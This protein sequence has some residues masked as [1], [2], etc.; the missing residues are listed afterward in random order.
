LTV[1][2]VIQKS[3]NIGAAKIANKLGPA[4]LDKYLREF[5]FGSKSGI[6][7]AGESSGLLRNLAKAHSIIDRVTVAF[8]QG[9]SVTPL[10]LTMAL[11]AMGNGGVLME[12]HIVKEIVDPQ[13]NKVQDFPP[14]PVRRVMSERAAQQ[15]LAIME[16]VTQQGGT[17][18]EAAVPG[19][20]VAGKTG[21]AQ[22][23]VGRAYSHSKFSALFIGMVPA[24]KPVLAISII[25]DE[26]KG[27]IFGGVVA[28]PIFREIAAQSLRILGYYPKPE[29]DKNTPV[30]VKGGAPAKGGKTPK[31]APAQMPA[32]APLPTLAQLLPV[33]LKETKEP[34]K[35]MPDLK[36]CTIREVLD[37]LNQTGLKCR[38]EGSGLAVTQD[39]SPGT[40]LTPGATCSVRFQSNS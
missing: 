18:K 5:G 21:T 38:L 39:P 1:Q 25:I 7:L 32:V 12:P 13:G 24:D 34:A 40:A 2:Q 6:T 17:A 35:V 26:P 37:L 19:F 10:Q 27:A 14:R 16:T 23:L 3:S 15:M 30:L 36:G 11:A 8:G 31:A 20:T 33:K 22:K 9:V 28:A 4:R 29:V